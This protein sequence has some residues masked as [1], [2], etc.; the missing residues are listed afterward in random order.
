MN[1]YFIY[2]LVI[3]Y[4]LS[5]VSCA[6]S[7]FE[8]NSNLKI[9]ADD[10]K[11]PP[12]YFSVISKLDSLGYKNE[13]IPSQLYSSLPEDYDMVSYYSDGIRPI[14]VVGYDSMNPSLQRA[15]DDCNLRFAVAKN[16]D[17][18]IQFITCESSGNTCNILPD[19]NGGLT[20]II[21]T[22]NR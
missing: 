4:A 21:C 5:F 9:S 3:F 7:P 2:I 20:I 11:A 18:S 16:K 8:D 12:S 22:T 14:V 6:K 1:R 15:M 19:G 10:P 13:T 17:G